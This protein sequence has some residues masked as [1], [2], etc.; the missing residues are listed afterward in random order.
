MKRLNNLV[1]LL[2][3]FLLPC[4]TDRKQPEIL[5][6]D[7]IQTHDFHEGRALILTN[8]GKYG[9]INRDQQMVIP[10]TFD[11]ACDFHES[12]ALVGMNRQDGSMAYQVVNPE[13][14]VVFGIA[15]DSCIIGSKYTDGLLW[16][17]DMRTGREGYLDR[18]GH[19]T[20]SRPPASTS[21]RSET[22]ARQS[23]SELSS[24]QTANENLTQ[25]LRQDKPISITTHNWR[26]VTAQNPFYQEARK[27]ITGK[28]TEED[29]ANRTMILNYVEHLR[30]SYT[31]KD[32]DFLQQLFS[33][34]ALIIVG[35]VV[36]PVPNREVQLPPQVTYNIVTKQHYI[37]RLRKVFAANKSIDVHF[38]DFAIRRHP[39]VPDIYGVTLRQRYRSDKYSDDGY[40]FLLWDFRDKTAPKIHVRTWQA[41]FTDGHTPLPPDSVFG[42]HNF[43]LR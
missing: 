16:Y 37:Q 22:P 29:A 17:M 25:T 43:N 34:N 6:T 33:E 28:L 23:G 1:I 5:P 30:T 36:R 13:G 38:S 10:P 41:A 4:C 7:I 14:K 24:Q 2:C 42:I 3:F 32:I 26:E 40:L 15:L 8:E 9:F 18:N 20:T 19:P 27:V 39:T 35:H 21:Y 11:Y 12:L 31:T